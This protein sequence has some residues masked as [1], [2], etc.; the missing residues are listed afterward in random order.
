MTVFTK[1]PFDSYQYI[2]I[3]CIQ[4]NKYNVIL[5]GRNISADLSGNNE[6]EYEY[7]LMYNP[8]IIRLDDIIGQTYEEEKT[9]GEYDNI[10]V[11]DVQTGSITFTVSIPTETGKVWSG[12]INMF[13]FT[14]LQSGNAVI[15]LKSIN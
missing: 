10:T 1:E 14:A 5:Q 11:T 8:L 13:K 2:D 6:R 12:A 3:N 7:I 9:V 4:N 15:Y